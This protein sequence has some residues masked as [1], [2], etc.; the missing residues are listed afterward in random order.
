MKKP[1]LILI[2]KFMRVLMLASV[3]FVTAML[4]SA[5]SRGQLLEK[6]RVTASFRNES[7]ESCMRR[8]RLLS[9]VEFAYNPAEL[10]Q[11]TVTAQ[12]FNR[13]PLGQV[14]SAL[15]SSTPLSFREMNN[16][17][18][19]YSRADGPVQQRRVTGTVR[20]S[21]GELLPSVTVRV[22][23]KTAGAVTDKDGAFSL[24]YNPGEVL[25]FS[26]LGYVQKEA[27][28][29]N[30]PLHIVLMEENAELKEVVIKGQVPPAQQKGDTLQYNADAYK[31]NPDASGEDLVK[32]MPG[33]TVENGTVKA[34]GE[35]VR[36]VTVD[37]K[38]FF[39]E[40][41]T[42]ALRNLPAE[43]ISKIEVFDRMS[44][45]AR[46]TGFDDGNS[47]KAINI[48]TRAEMRQGQFGK[49]YAGYGTDGRYSAGGNIN[50][51]KDEKRIS[52]IG[53]A[54]KREPAELFLRRTC[55]ACRMRVPAGAVAVEAAAVAVAGAAVVLAAAVSAGEEATSS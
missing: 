34:G 50:L 37:G 44:D 47:T 29:G 20:S 6:E 48:V 31:V 28:P 2:V 33:I 14:L 21:T 55:W 9:G 3:L 54:N 25:V 7:L 16:S 30:G 46:F 10:K 38:E 42:L 17:I 26:L 22:K 43:V 51:F 13:Q 39:G 11:F 32:K 5:S 52:I 24:D 45:Q 19:I 40:D 49:V 1:P 8:L 41:A 15:L 4:A 36:K 27:V 18:V 35:E 12:S 23:G 53:I